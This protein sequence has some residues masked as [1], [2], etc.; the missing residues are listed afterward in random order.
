[1][2]FVILMRGWKMGIELEG[3]SGISDVSYLFTRLRLAKKE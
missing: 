2:N 3:I 1:M